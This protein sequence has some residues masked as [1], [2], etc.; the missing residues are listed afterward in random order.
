MTHLFDLDDF[1]ETRIAAHYFN[2]CDHRRYNVEGVAAHIR[3]CF[4]NVCHWCGEEWN[5]N[6]SIGWADSHSLDAP[7][8]VYAPLCEKQWAFLNHCT[9]AAWW[10]DGRIDAATRAIVGRS[11]DEEAAEYVMK[12]G[13]LLAHRVAAVPMVVTER[14]VGL[15]AA[16]VGYETERAA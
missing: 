10:L 8:R 1:T 7:N 3:D 2:G 14:G 16:A 9:Y 4:G 11:D 5:G 12:R 6:W 15:V 13:W